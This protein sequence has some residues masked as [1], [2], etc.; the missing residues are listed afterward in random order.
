MKPRSMRALGVVS[1]LALAGVA[2]TATISTAAPVE[3]SFSY[4]GRLE[5]G[6]EAYTGAADFRVRA[7][8]N[9]TGDLMLGSELAVSA[10]VDEGVFMLDLDL[11]P[12]VFI[13]D[14]VWLEIDVRTPGDGGAYTTL[15]PRQR[16]APAPYAKFALAGN[17]GPQGPQGEPGPEGPAG[18]DGATGPQGP[19]GEAGP[20]GPTGPTGPQGPAGTTSW[21][22]LTGI[23]SGFADGIDNNTTYLAGQGL[24][25]SGG[26]FRIPDGGIYPSLLS[27]TADWLS[28]VSDGLLDI[29]DPGVNARLGVG[30]GTPTDRLH[31]STSG[32]SAFRVQ[33]DGTTRLRVNENG[34]VAIGANNTSVGGGNLYVAERLGIG[35]STPDSYLHLAVPGDFGDGMLLTS[36]GGTSTLFAPGE[37]ITNQTY[38]F[39]ADTDLNFNAADDIELRADDI[40]RIDSESIAFVNGLSE[41]DLTS[42]GKVDINAGSDVDIDGSVVTVESST[43][44]GGFLGVNTSSLSFN[45]SVNGSAA[46]TGGGLWAVFS[47][48]RLKK[49][50]EPMATGALDSLLSLEGVT[51]EYKNPGHFSYDPGVH[52]GWIAQQ[53]QTVFPEW[54]VVDDEGYLAIQP[55]GYEALV[56][57]A[58]R[59]MRAEKDA[60]LAEANAALEASHRRID[61]LEREN[62]SMRARLARIEAMLAGDRGKADR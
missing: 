3:P 45:L 15:S 32:Q 18:A 56:V 60:Q 48:R 54:I 8:D 35:D 31:V 40:I 41:V 44:M 13:G 20:Q 30:N 14:D 23:P 55:E 12:L 24:Q 25:L 42:A 58:I 43:F 53:V 33:V 21:S 47:D 49:N 28:F 46:K 62:T 27:G 61:T 29:D 50:I 38:S 19:A 1:L 37:F 22:G 6:G 16:V 9:A 39:S 59:E 7:Y 5:S 2:A 36:S 4:Q 34:G 10:T 51:F 57:E 52:T 17:E 26:L 11:G